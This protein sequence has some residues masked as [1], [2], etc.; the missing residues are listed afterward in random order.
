M[1]QEISKQHANRLGRIFPCR[2]YSRG[3][4][5]AGNFIIAKDRSQ[6][7]IKIWVPENAVITYSPVSKKQVVLKVVEEARSVD[8]WSDRRT[9]YTKKPVTGLKKGIM[10]KKDIKK[11]KE[12]KGRYLTNFTVPGATKSVIQYKVVNYGAGDGGWISVQAKIRQTTRKTTTHFLV[13]IDET[14]PFITVLKNPVSTVKQAHAEL[15]PKGLSKKAKR[16]GE[17]FFEPVSERLNIKLMKR[18]SESNIPK[19]VYNYGKSIN[20]VL[21][22][23]NKSTHKCENQ[24]K[25]DGVKYVIGK[26]YDSRK[27]NHEDLVLTKWH[28][29]V[30]NNERQFVFQTANSYKYD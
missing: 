23:E 15:R 25:V 24:L 18:I 11:Y 19:Y 30:R 2:T 21:N 16:Q 26:V 20:T 1:T 12:V 29:V 8:S 28:K 14:T 9:I 13:G 6:K 27:G 10:S 7:H 17:W 3:P 22:L 5:G 4:N